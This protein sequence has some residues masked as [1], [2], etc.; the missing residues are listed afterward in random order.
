MNI[1][2][3]GE[4]E[5]N[6]HGAP[7]RRF[8]QAVNFTAIKPGKQLL[9][10]I[11]VQTMDFI[12]EKYSAVRRFKRPL[13]VALCAGK[14]ALHVTKQI[15]GKQFRVT[16]ILCAVKTDQRRIRFQYPLR[17]RILVHELRHIA[18]SGPALTGDQQ[19]QAA[20]RIKQRRLHLLN[21]FLQAFIMTNQQREMVR[22]WQLLLPFRQ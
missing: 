8:A 18:F 11:G 7:L 5:P 19:R 9:L 22:W 16:G 3:G 15:G 4:D 10:A 6:L 20:V 17:Q 13:P 1:L 14:C 2:G 21:R 12:K